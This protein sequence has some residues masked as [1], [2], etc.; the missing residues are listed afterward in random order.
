[1]SDKDELARLHAVDPKR[2]VLVQ[3]PAGSGKTSL[4]V[5]RYLALLGVVEAPE[6]ILAITFTRK[7]AAEMRERVLQLLDPNFEPKKPHER[8]A[9]ALA[10]AVTSK[11]EQWGLRENPQRL[12]I[13]TIDSFSHF[14]ARSMPIASQLGPVPMST[15]Q[16]TTLYSEAARRALAKLDD[17]D[18]IGAHVSTLLLWRDHGAQDLEDLLINML[19][20]R[21]QWLPILLN[22]VSTDREKLEHGLYVSVSERLTVLS[23][24][25]EQGLKDNGVDPQELVRLMNF[26]T[27]QL[28]TI[29][30]QSILCDLAEVQ[31]LPA[32]TPDALLHWQAL[33]EF[34]LSKKG[35][36][37]KKVDVNSGFPP[38]VPE[39][40]AMMDMLDQLSVTESVAQALQQARTLPETSYSDDEW[41][42]LGAMLEVLKSAA[43][44]LSLVFS[45]HNKNDFIGLSAAA[46]QA[47]GD[48]DNGYTDLALYL[49]KRIH[50]LLVDEYQDTNRSQF[51]LIEKLIGAWQPTEDRSLFLVGDPMQSIY[52]F[53]E[54][55]VGLF[56][57]TKHY[58]IGGH[59]LDFRQLSRNF[60][61]Q[62]TIVEWVNNKLGQIFPT[63]EDISAGAVAYAPSA[64]AQGVGGQV[65][66][67]AA[68]DAASEAEALV[69][70]LK[71]ILEENI[72]DPEF[73]AAVLVRTRSH[74]KELL[75]ALERHQVPYRAVKLDPLSHRPII[76]DLLAL[77]RAVL[78][79]DDRASVLALLRSPACGLTLADLHA[80]AGDKRDLYEEDALDRLDKEARQRAERVFKVLE[81]A[82]RLWHRRSIRDL[83]EG[84]WYALGGPAL[85]LRPDIDLR[86][87]RLYFDILEQAE[88]E[89]LL[90]DW[91]GFY[92]RL[93]KA[94]TEGDP[95]SEGVKLEVMTMHGAKGLEWDLVVLPQLHRQ[96][97]SPDRELLNWL[98]LTTESRDQQLLLAPLRNARE[99][100]NSPLVE[101]IR[102]EQKQREAYERQRLLY[103]ACTRAKKHLILSACLN[104]EKLDTVRNGSLLKDLWPTMAREFLADLAARTAH[105]SGIK[106]EHVETAPDQSIRRIPINWDP[107]VTPAF[108]WRPPFVPREHTVDIEFNWVGAEARRIGTVLHRLLERIGRIG[109]ESLDDEDKQSLLG[110][111]PVLLGAMGS[112]GPALEKSKE[113]VHA[114]L[115]QTL[116]SETGRWI[117]S[118]HHQDAACEL[119]LSG[120]I[121]GRLVNAV[122]DR[123]FIDEK[124]VRWIIDYK[125]GYHSGGNLDKFLEEEAKRYAPQLTQYRQLFEGLGANQIQTALYLA[126]HDYLKCLGDS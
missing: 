75:P 11:V 77:T 123:T 122:I 81:Q 82:S 25:V 86:N 69:A 54:A 17:G 3:A 33:G 121:D 83:V 109:I 113:V 7:A 37:R 10:K 107:K 126:R 67:I 52:R 72:N 24:Q 116:S 74:L 106:G 115:V 110:R 28:K 38:D 62:E 29:G 19:A 100:K 124:G 60:R 88:E 92:D 114:A 2:S 71:S 68:P 13:R 35:V 111:I 34:L 40:K 103:V 20:R 94:Q 105:P 70:N 87:A 9:H 119:A 48:A 47:L 45:E 97:R 58:G 91:N 39:K 44:E 99:S 8:R 65:Q 95:A 16:P 85:Y 31:S 27:E 59:T 36:W 57:Q 43:L 6:E 73:K 98:S 15:D 56:M 112:V 49:D 76:Q 51:Q 108:D 53:R 78:D 30:A 41:L 42:V 22:P 18:A 84:A 120:V 80:L 118:G 102:A 96:G 90:P 14:L 125:S 63:S 55:E 61:S 21:E 64:S 46:Q 50:H 5:E 26:A 101:F 1:M 79:P 89:G 104:P 32:P 12:M 117:L 66:V 93:D 4:L 23:A